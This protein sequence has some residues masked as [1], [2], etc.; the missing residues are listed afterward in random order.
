M[1]RASAPSFDLFKLIV[2]IVLVVILILMLLRGC[3]TTTA[4]PLTRENG[5]TSEPSQSV[6]SVTQT[7]AAPPTNTAARATPSSAPSAT[8]TRVAATLT[9]TSNAA[10]PS[11]APPTAT[12]VSTA[13][14][15]ATSVVT[16]TTT[17][18][19]NPSCNTSVP[20]RL[21][22]GQTARIVQRL[23]MRDAASITAP[24]LTTNPV[25][26][27]VE[28]IGGPVC[29]PVGD[30]AYLWWQIR[31]A[32]RAEGWSAESPLNEATYLLEPV[33]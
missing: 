14:E 17:T 5:S 6:G 9:P 25:D 13:A 2:T 30:G 3:A 21:R 11:S 18:A 4:A 7:E 29:T 12:A 31:L 23:N 15:T 1:T 19:D 24:V 8:S 28:I 22:M 10:T 33:P 26:A 32:N 27:R 20:S 16:P